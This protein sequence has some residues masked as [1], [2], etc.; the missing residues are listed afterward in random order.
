M[1]GCADTVAGSLR[2][3]YEQAIAKIRE[4]HA[5]DRDRLKALGVES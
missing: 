5:A 4:S 3:I 1:F 2:K